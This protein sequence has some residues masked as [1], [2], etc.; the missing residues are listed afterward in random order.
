MTVGDNFIRSIH[1]RQTTRLYINRWA[2][3]RLWY[4]SKTRLYPEIKEVNYWYTNQNQ[5]SWNHF[6]KKQ[7]SIWVYIAR[8]HLYKILKKNVNPL[9]CKKCKLVYRKTDSEFVGSRVETSTVRRTD[10][11]LA[12][13]NI[14]VKWMCI[15]TVEMASWVCTGQNFASCT[16]SIR[17]VS[18]MSVVAM[19]LDFSFPLYLHTGWGKWLYS[20]TWEF[21]VTFAPMMQPYVNYLQFCVSDSVLMLVKYFM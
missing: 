5:A 2:S 10:Y 17:S 14:W 19:A 3:N 1:N 15:L 4:S 9:Y 6:E 11:K 13:G 20:Q 21:D 7:D 8:F 12:Q 18:Y 16:L